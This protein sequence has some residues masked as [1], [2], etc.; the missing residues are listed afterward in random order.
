MKTLLENWRRYGKEVESIDEGVAEDIPGTSARKM[1]KAVDTSEKE[2]IDQGRAILNKKVGDASKRNVEPL[3]DFLNSP[4]G[5]DPKV[6]AA[7][8]VGSKDG[9]PGDEAIS[10]AT[11]T[12]P[13][14]A[15]N[16]T[17]NEISLSKSI[18]WPLSS[19]KSL[20]NMATGDPSGKGMRI[21]SSGDLVIDG[22]HRWSSTWAVCPECAINAIDIALPGGAPLEKLA[23]AQAAIA[24]TMDPNAG[25]IPKAT[26][27]GAKDNILGAKA[28]AIAALITRLA[29]QTMDSGHPLLGDK[30]IEAV[31]GMPEG[32]KYFG[33]DQSMDT[34]AARQTIINKV[35]Q[36]L[37]NLPGPQ[38]PER[39]YMPQFDGGDTHKG[40][41]SLGKVVD[42][43]KSGEVNYKAPFEE[44]IRRMVKEVLNDKQNS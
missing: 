11:A 25:D 6:R 44:S 9:A 36:N 41:V 19:A 21:V 13:V 8:G 3:V 20:R 10:A 17:Q 18:G 14:K 1:K 5:K 42:K 31:K 35:A 34:Q 40:Q 22:H 4:E 32:K 30:Y 23:A 12:P 33:I 16:P 15:L 7:L 24:A 39:D 28:P 43:M 29:G 27:G 37:S 38:G 26:T 2:Y